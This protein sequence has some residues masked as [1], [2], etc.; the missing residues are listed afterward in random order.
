MLFVTAKYTATD[1]ENDSYNGTIDC[2]I[3]DMNKRDIFIN[4]NEVKNYII[5]EIKHRRNHRNDS[6]HCT[7]TFFESYN[8]INDVHE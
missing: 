4:L 7:I 2:V 6:I 5:D 8:D 3:P 1:Y